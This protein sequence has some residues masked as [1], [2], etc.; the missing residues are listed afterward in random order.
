MHTKCCGRN[1]YTPLKQN[2][3]GYLKTHTHTHTHT[4]TCSGSPVCCWCAVTPP[5]DP[6]PLSAAAGSSPPGRR[7]SYSHSAAA[8]PSPCNTKAHIQTKGSREGRRG[9]EQENTKQE[10]LKHDRKK[11]QKLDTICKPSISHITKGTPL[12]SDQLFRRFLHITTDQADVKNTSL[13][14]SQPLVSDLF[15][16]LQMAGRMFLHLRMEFHA[17]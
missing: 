7:A 16:I 8:P 12:P 5:D 17:C 11:E 2:G 14:I 1:G 13:P 10:K 15:W 6:A 9:R 3:L 4:H